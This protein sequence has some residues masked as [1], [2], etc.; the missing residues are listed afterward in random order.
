MTVHCELLE[1]RIFTFGRPKVTF[2]YDYSTTLNLRIYRQ[3]LRYVYSYYVMKSCRTLLTW[4]STRSLVS[5]NNFFPLLPSPLSVFTVPRTISYDES[6]CY[7]FSSILHKPSTNFYTFHFSKIY[8]PF[9][10]HIDINSFIN[11][12]SPFYAILGRKVRPSYTT[13]L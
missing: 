8:Y 1:L 13:N 11:I 6:Q 10:M 3:Y 4:L 12:F 5:F 7:F 9:F 2:A